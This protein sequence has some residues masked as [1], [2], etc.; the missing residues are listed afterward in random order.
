[1]TIE[2]GPQYTIQNKGVVK[3]KEQGAMA[4]ET[5]PRYTIQN[6]KGVKH[7][8]QGVITLKL[9]SGTISQTRE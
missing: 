4:I 6:K 9:V 8:E 2:I 3:H 5:G 1:M 7:K